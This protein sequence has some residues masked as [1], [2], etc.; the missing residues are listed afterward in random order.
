MARNLS[1]HLTGAS[2][3]E[4]GNRGLGY[5][6]AFVAGAINAGGFLAVQQYTSHM[7][8]IVS[9]MA[10]LIAVGQYRIALFG[11][12]CLATFI[13][14]AACTAVL[15]NYAR[16]RQLQSEYAIPLLLE[17]SLLMAFGILGTQ[18]GGLQGAFVT[19][20][21]LLLCF[22]MGLQNAVIT[23]I[24][25]AVIRTTHVT[26]IATDLGIDLGRWVFR[27]T[28]MRAEFVPTSQRV[29]MLAILLVSFFVGG[30]TGA[31]GFQTL[32]YAATLPL[33]AALVAAAITPV[34]DDVKDRKRR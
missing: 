3:T 23:K 10:D 6:L 11:L 9:E 21:I 17:A 4:S 22:V 2:R 27:K 26:G 30:L 18:I 28:A 14:G 19:V 32:G 34:F 7:T 1:R 31:V 20:T 25:G 15:V 13:G 8:G 24:S 29:P 5:L 16:S 33:A 12:A